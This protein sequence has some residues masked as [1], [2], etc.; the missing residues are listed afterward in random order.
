MTGCGSPMAAR[1]PPA[2]NANAGPRGCIPVVHISPSI[3]ERCLGRP[4]TEKSSLTAASAPASHAS[5]EGSADAGYLAPAGSTSGTAPCPWIKVRTRTS[6]GARGYR[7]VVSVTPSARRYRCR[8]GRASSEDARAGMAD[9]IASSDARMITPA[10]ACSNLHGPLAG[11]S[12]ATLATVAF[13]CNE[14]T[15]AFRP[16]PSAVRPTQTRS[17]ATRPGDRRSTGPV[18]TRISLSDSPGVRTRCPR[19]TGWGGRR[20]SQVSSRSARDQP[21]QTRSWRRVAGSYGHR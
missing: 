19:G 13:R 5:L 10:I 18:C 6:F 8:I 21:L 9:E 17:R 7:I 3:I 1:F 4:C 12:L 15:H 14:P 20:D 16:A 11:S 2:E